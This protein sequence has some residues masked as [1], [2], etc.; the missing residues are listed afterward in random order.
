MALSKFRLLFFVRPSFRSLDLQ[1]V[2]EESAVMNNGF[3]E[4]RQIGSAVLIA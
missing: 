1:Q 3:V 2:V 4:I